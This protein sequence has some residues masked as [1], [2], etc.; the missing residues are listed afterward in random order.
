M[1][2][3]AN[4]KDSVAERV[5]WM[6]QAAAPQVL[7]LVSRSLDE[8]RIPFL[9]V[10]GILTTRLFYEDTASRPLGDID[11]RIPP[12]HLRNVTRI[13][14][15]HGWPVHDDAPILNTLMLR[16]DG[17]EVDVEGSLG[18][19]GL[20]AL[21]VEDLLR[22]ARRSVEPFGFAHLQP[23]IN[24]HALVLAINAFKDGLRPM[25]WAVEDLRRIC[26]QPDF[27][28]P[29]LVDRAA[30]GRV[31][32]VLWLVARWLF[33]VHGS[34]PWGRVSESIGPTPPS[35]RVA[36]YYEFVR[37]KGWPPKA[38]LLVT[39]A[40]SDGLLRSASGLVLAGAGVCHGR[41][42]RRRHRAQNDDP[43]PRPN[44]SVDRGNR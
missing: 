2:P 37:S 25:P 23:E 18:P 14:R 31:L 26:S 20:C 35:R 7:K 5:N 8:A 17:W 39:A 19:P 12:R 15:Q 1:P 29:I 24:D 13:A 21:T 3:P 44:A 6:R 36:R 40:S 4:T 32:T 41:I 30:R 10:K 42:M 16:V 27:S 38:G 43:T 11:V 34:R 9:P 28:A 33:E 22:R